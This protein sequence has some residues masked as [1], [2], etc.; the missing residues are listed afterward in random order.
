ME[1]QSRPISGTHALPLYAALS[2]DELLP[3]S[4]GAWRRRGDRERVVFILHEGG[5]AP[6]EGRAGAGDSAA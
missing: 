4:R 6:T 3:V 1:A 2:Q 5:A